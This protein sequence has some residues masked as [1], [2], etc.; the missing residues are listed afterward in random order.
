MFGNKTILNVS[1]EQQYQHTFERA[2]FSVATTVPCCIFLYINVTMLFTLWTKTLF[3]ETSRY[4]L[5]FNLLFGDTVQMGMS[6]VLYLVA[7]C[8]TKLSYPL[9]GVLSM[10]TKLTSKISPITLVVMSLERY[11][12]VCH[13]LRHATVVTRRTTHVAV[14]GIWT[15]S[16]LNVFVHVLL[17]L[18]FPFA[19]LESLQM[20]DFCSNVALLLGQMS[21]IYEKAITCTLFVSATLAILSSYVGVIVAARTATTNKASIKKARNTLLLHL[22]QLALS[23][24]STV[25]TPMLIALSRITTR[26][27]V[28]RVQNFL[29]LCVI[30]LPR[31]LSAL[32]Y[33]MRD[34]NIR[35]A[36]VQNLSCCCP[37]LTVQ[38]DK[39]SFS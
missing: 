12:A 27:T 23:L 19:E 28:V 5:L 3:Q 17:M 4:I 16:S 15:L 7:A 24:S 1:N 36:L 37:S 11:I 31:C 8:R 21:D 18:E 14:V 22:A 39:P 30:I 35:P 38:V 6:Q 20:K 9:C 10:I 13:P 2:L 34:R 33:G 26:L 29:Y 25:Y 32:I